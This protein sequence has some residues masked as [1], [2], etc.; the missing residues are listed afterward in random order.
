MCVLINRT[1][2]L[3]FQVKL[4]LVSRY[5]NQ[6]IPVELKCNVTARSQLTYRSHPSL[7]VS[8]S[9]EFLGKSSADHTPPYLDLDNL[10]SRSTNSSL[11]LASRMNKILVLC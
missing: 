3:D 2:N 10:S 11:S 1:Q 4:P 5:F 9:D 7:D 6:S 8:D